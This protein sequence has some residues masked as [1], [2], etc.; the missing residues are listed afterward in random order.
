MTYGEYKRRLHEL[1]FTCGMNMRYHHCL[2]WRWGM[3]DKIVRI[4]VG[5]LAIF[6]LVYAV[7]DFLNPLSGLI[8]AVVSLVAA[9]VL[10]IVPV[11]DRE[12]HHGELFRLWGDLR[13]DAVQEEHKTCESEDD[14][15]ANKPRFERLCE[16]VQK[17]DALNSVESAPWK[18][19]LKKCYWEEEKSE[20]AP[21]SQDQ[22]HETLRQSPN[23]SAPGVASASKAEA[24]VGTAAGG[25][26]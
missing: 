3:A 26:G 4:I 15:E 11:G 7:P 9:A 24:E 14:K 23:T 17:S 2:E 22:I 10:N 13:S 1:K 12:K 18:G 8:I 19:L 25:P 16:L 21:T 20:R 5:V 6:G